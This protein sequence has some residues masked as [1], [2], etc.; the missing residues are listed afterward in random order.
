MSKEG[1]ILATLTDD[2]A[3]KLVELNSEKE[4]IML[5]LNEIQEKLSANRFAQNQSFGE[6]RDK[7]GIPGGSIYYS[8]S[9]KTL[10]KGIWREEK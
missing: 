7:Y 8:G 9:D 5:I 3:S 2:E 10:R 1:E 4:S 6:L